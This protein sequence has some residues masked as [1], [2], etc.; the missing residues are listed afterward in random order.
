MGYHFDEHYREHV[1][2]ADGSR[3]LLRLVRPEDKQLLI[4]GFSRLSPESR[5]LRFFTG[6]GRLTE[7]ELHYFTE[8]DHLRHFAIGAL[9]ED[10]AEHGVGVARFVCL[11]EDPSIAEPAFTVVD[12]WQGKGLGRVLFQRLLAAAKERG[13]KRFRIE[14][15]RENKAMLDLIEMTCSEA[16]CTPMGPVMQVEFEIPD[17]A[18]DAGP[19]DSSHESAFYRFFRRASERSEFFQR[20][21]ERLTEFRLGLWKA[22]GAASEDD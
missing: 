20:A 19:A 6:K 5:Y 8:V 21:A 3:V 12:A 11:K 17:V 22:E 10:G 7:Q 18:P 14:V 4:E 1:K 13:V 15:L 9:V 2:L 16:V